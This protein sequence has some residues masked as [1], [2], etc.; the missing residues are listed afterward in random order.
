MIMPSPKTKT[1]A[2]ATVAVALLALTGCSL[3]ATQ[4]GSSAPSQS[5]LEA[6]VSL[7]AALESTTKDITSA[8][9]ELSSKPAAAAQSF[10]DLAAT[11]NK[12]VAKIINPTIKKAATK[13]ATSLT[14]VALQLNKAISDPA[15]AD[16]A[17]VNA[18]QTSLQTNFG[19][20]GKACS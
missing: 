15:N 8:S 12:N 5:R 7:K 4:S 1:F 6:C 20:L 9:T 19:A 17:A 10:T 3:G 14:A 13:A 18:S 2:L 11:F 16:L